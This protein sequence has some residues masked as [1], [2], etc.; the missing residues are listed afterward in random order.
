MINKND[1]ESKF[2][3]NIESKIYDNWEKKGY[4]KAKI[5]KSK[6]PFT[7]VM[8]PPNITGKL[9]MG[10]ALDNT[11][12]DVLIRYNRMKKVPTLWIPGTDHAS[13]AT[14]V[15]VAE[16]LLKQGKTKEELGREEFLKEAWKWKDEFGGEITNQLRKLGCSCDWDMERFTMDELCSDAVLEVFVKLYEKGLVYKGERLINWCPDCKTSISEN[17]V[18]YEE[19]NSNLWYIKYPV[20]NSNE[21]L[22]IATTR[23]ETMLGDTALAVNPNDDRYKHLVGKRAMLPLL[24]KYIDIISDEYV[25][26]EFGTGVVKITPAHDP[27]DFEVGKRHNLEII[28]ILNEDA[29]L[30]ENGGIY[31]G[32]TREEARKNIVSD[33]EKQGYLVETK[34]Y[35]HNVG[36]CYR[37]H[38][39]VEPYISMQW[40]VKMDELVKPALEAVR[41]G[42]I[43]FIPKRFEKHYF[44]WM[45]NI[46]DWCISRQLWWG[47]RIPAYYCD[48]CGKMIV[49]KEKPHSCDCGGNLSQDEDSLDT[50]FSS[51]LWP[52]STLG[53]PKPTPEYEYFYPTSTLVTGYDIIT[54]WVSKMIFSAIEYTGKIPFEKVYVHGLVRDSQGRK[55]SKSLGNGINPIELID[56]YGTDALRFSL[57]QGIS[58][59]NDIR[60]IPEKIESARN[61]TNK[62]WNAARFIKNYLT[63]MKSDKIDESSLLPEDKWILTKL[64]ELILTANENMEKYEIGISL[65]SIYDFIWFDF[66]DWY[67]EMVKTRLYDKESSGY[68]TAISTLNFVMCNF[69]KLLHPFMPFVTEE[70]YSHLYQT[71]ETI[72]LSNWPEF[73]EALYF[74][75]TKKSVDKIID[76]IG[77]IRNVRSKVDINSK[78]AINS[79]IKILDLDLEKEVKSSELYIKRLSYIDEIK[80]ISNDFAVPSEYTAINL[81][82]MDIYLDLG[83]LVDKE[84][85]IS[86][87]EIEKSKILA[88]LKRAEGMLKNEAF[89]KKAPEKLIEQEKE[90]IAKYSELLENINSRIEELK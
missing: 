64:N 56:K 16:K 58:P 50:W 25:D 83:A 85:Q 61:F 71:D 82:G 5:D 40:F 84:M 52:F 35:V 20:E 88:E 8:P 44:N 77:K 29:T 31:V 47:H 15:K 28:N 30:N 13:I 32:Q 57:I 3:S 54:F 12:Q 2:D 19:K 73:N 49:S 18:D 36:S 87:L 69:L 90:K 65:Q 89:V 67:I 37:C 74:E 62:I 17:E 21:S 55:M 48:K 33:L 80:Y 79:M 45:E 10:H 76:A 6:K 22:I 72:M 24:N 66:C 26:I 14:E 4:F 1:M 86:N 46:Q 59:G 43:E 60:Y 81:E 51:A 9:H 78:K 7:I 63:D 75:E 11:I 23:P 68:E 42:S 39:T 27:N 53:W 41:D 70:I 34:P 38:N